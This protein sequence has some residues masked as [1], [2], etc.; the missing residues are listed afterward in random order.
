MKKIFLTLAATALL[1]LLSTG[2][3]QTRY[4]VDEY[5]NVTSSEVIDFDRPFTGY[6]PEERELIKYPPTMT[7]EEAEAYID[8]HNADKEAKKKAEKEK[9][10]N[11]PFK[12]GGGGGGC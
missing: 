4:V 6:A 8:K 11:N 7:Y 1:S 9:E 10:K 5:G 2:C 3:V 12:G